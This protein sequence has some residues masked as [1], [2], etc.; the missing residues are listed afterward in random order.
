LSI[1]SNMDGKAIPENIDQA[2]SHLT[3]QRL[4]KDYLKFRIVVTIKRMFLLW[5]KPQNGMGWPTPK[6]LERGFYPEFETLILNNNYASLCLLV[7][8]YSPYV[9]FKLLAISWRMGIVVFFL[10]VF[11]WLRHF[12]SQ[13]QLFLFM[14][15]SLVLSQS[16][17]VAMVGGVDSRLIAEIVPAMEVIAVSMFAPIIVIIRKRLGRVFTKEGIHGI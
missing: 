5:I 8:K 1:L 6:S 16:G 11:G 7:S 10:F 3:E 9:F 2:F 15:A 12:K 14:T 13:D 17:F 4:K